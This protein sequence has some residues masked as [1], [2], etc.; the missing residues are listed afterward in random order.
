[1]SDRT[2][3]TVCV[4]YK[5]GQVSTYGSRRSYEEALIQ[6]N[7]ATG[8]INPEGSHVVAVWVMP[9][10]VPRR[11]TVRRPPRGKGAQVFP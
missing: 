7:K 3:F 10:E 8:A 4:E 5:D 2:V 11:R 6:A 9:L 1:M